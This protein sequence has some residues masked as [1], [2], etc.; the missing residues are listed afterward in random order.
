MP[1]DVPPTYM[2]HISRNA[3]ELERALRE[4]T[5]DPITIGQVLLREHAINVDTLRTALKEQHKT[6]NRKLG[7]ILADMGALTRAQVEDAVTATL[8]FPT[9]QLAEFDFD[10]LA[11]LLV[12]GEQAR[13]YHLIPLMF[14]NNALVLAVH[15]LP[16]SQTRELLS[17]MVERPIQ[18][19]LSTQAEIDDA[20]ARTY[21]ALSETQAL[22]S[23]E[24]TTPQQTDQEFMWQE[25]DR[26]AQEQ[27]VVK[28]VHA[29]LTEA[30]A[31]H[32]SDIHIRPGENSFELLYRI[33]GTLIGKRELPKSLLPAIVSRIKV[34]S[35]LNI[36]EHRLPQDGHI[37][38]RID[39]RQVD[40]RVSIIPVQYGESVVIRLLDKSIGLRSVDEIG[41]APADRARFLDLLKRSFGV[42]LVTGPTGSGKSTTL[43]AALLEVEKENINVITVEDPIEYDLPKTRQIQVLPIINFG[44]P[45]ALRYILRHDPDV[46]MVG[47]IR[48]GETCKIAVESALTGHLVFSTLHT[49]D[50]PSTLVRLMEMGVAPYMIRSAVIGVLAQRLVRRNCEFCLAVEDVAPLVRENLGIGP[51]EIFYRSRGCERCHMTGFSGRMAIYELLVMNDELRN[52]VKDDVGSD[53]YLKLAI[54]GGM[55][56]LPQ[57]GLMQARARKVSL[58]EVY[59]ACM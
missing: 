57:N 28:M 55:M 11:I 5:Q 54:K 34:L 45:E 25:A 36:A 46:I 13:K 23:L 50:A 42:V 18:F 41:F 29:A 32:A 7:E 22:E 44:F 58:N 49:N 43:Y 4:G 24:E 8:E 47:E 31:Q 51:D 30:I 2:Q 33:D 12:P 38:F 59:R 48:D 1:N 53:E 6:P 19:A 39:K 26:L 40:M 9:A 17:F 56:T 10:P 20:I 21:Y 27:P 14:H 16:D 52:S 3:A 15:A 35:R 37:R